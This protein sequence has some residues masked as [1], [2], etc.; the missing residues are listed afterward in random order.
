MYGSKWLSLSLAEILILLWWYF[1]KNALCQ[2]LNVGL[3]PKSH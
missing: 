3:K 1:V 2:M